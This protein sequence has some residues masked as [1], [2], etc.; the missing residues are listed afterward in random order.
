MTVLKDTHIRHLGCIH[1]PVLALPKGGVL[2]ALAKE[3]DD[4]NY[5]ANIITRPVLQ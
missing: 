1:T 3:V 5:L 4:V 2:F